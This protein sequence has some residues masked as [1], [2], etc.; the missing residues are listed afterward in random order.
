MLLPLKQ[1]LKQKLFFLEFE[2]F[3]SCYATSIKTRIE[4][5]V[6]VI[7]FERIS[8]LLCYFH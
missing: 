1:G 8:G 7:L 6:G 4:T 2:K 3:L 5:P